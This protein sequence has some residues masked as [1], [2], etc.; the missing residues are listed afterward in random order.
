MKFKK[1]GRRIT[2]NGDIYGKKV[3]YLPDKINK[4]WYLNNCG[5][6]G[7]AYATKI[8]KAKN[9]FIWI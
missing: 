2:K 7:I 9:C 8:L 5:L 3:R 1:S 6:L 4:Y